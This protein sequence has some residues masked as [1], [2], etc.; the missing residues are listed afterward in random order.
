MKN[1][2][3]LF[4]GASPEHEVSVITGLQIFENIDRDLYN[5]IP[6]FVSEKGQFYKLKPI[7]TRKDY[8]LGTK[9]NITFGF[10]EK[11]K[12]P[13]ISSGLFSKEYIHC[14]INTL[15]GGNGESGPIAGLLESYS[16]PYTSTNVESSAICMNKALAKKLVD[17]CVPILPSQSFTSS[18]INKNTKNIGSTI[19]QNVGLPVIVKPVHLGSSIGIKIAKDATELE[20]YLL[21]ASHIDTEV[22]AEKY[23]SNISEFNCS[24]RTHNGKT[25]TS[26]IE[27]PMTKTEI[28]SFSDKYQRGSKKTSGGM[29]SLSRELPA[30]ISLD[31]EKK[32]REF[33]IKIYEACKCK[34]V[35]RIDF[36]Q[37]TGG[38][39][40]FNEIN[41]IPG[42][43][44]FY[45]WEVLGIPFKQQ[46]SELIEES[47]HNKE[48]GES[49]NFVHKTD[50]IEKFIKNLKN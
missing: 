19:A 28:L 13:Y 34:G 36:I 6:V 22:M 11:E 14:A 15:H 7:A 32:I 38:E 33:S 50:I 17:N 35:V 5:P 27:R 30:N 39:I 42:S 1:I 29:A 49:V 12:K 2:L 46:I 45:L 24:V 21:E 18:E 25:E 4:G 43:M 3:V 20:L 8:S 31:L 48:L 16:I 41:P 10:D 23:L 40:Y 47:V 44:A 9:T 26:A 37:D